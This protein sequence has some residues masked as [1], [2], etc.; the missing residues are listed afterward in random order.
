MSERKS[1]AQIFERERETH[2]FERERETDLSEE[3][4]ETFVFDFLFLFL[5][6]LSNQAPKPIETKTK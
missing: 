6:F 4:F 2:Q 3:K 1:E 5:H